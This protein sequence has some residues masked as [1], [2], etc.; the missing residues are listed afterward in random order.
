MSTTPEAALAESPCLAKALRPEEKEQVTSGALRTRDEHRRMDYRL[1]D[2]ALEC[3]R[4]ATL[5]EEWRCPC[6]RESERQRALQD[7][8]AQR[9]EAMALR[10]RL[11][12]WCE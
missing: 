9:E 10:R 6:E 4:L 7:L 11:R 2:V 12:A 3:V 1:T 8:A 5:L